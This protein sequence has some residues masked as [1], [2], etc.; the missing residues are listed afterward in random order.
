MLEQVRSILP[1][2]FCEKGSL[3]QFQITPL[4]ATQWL[5]AVPCRWSPQESL[6]RVSQNAG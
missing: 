1:D 3:Q 4:I 2:C 5:D 6:F